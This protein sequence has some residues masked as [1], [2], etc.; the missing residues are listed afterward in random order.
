MLVLTLKLLL[1][2][3]LLSMGRGILM[4]RFMFN[5]NSRS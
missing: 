5:I 3:L 4:L 2:E 1:T